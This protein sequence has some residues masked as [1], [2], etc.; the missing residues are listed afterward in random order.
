MVR[1]LLCIASLAAPPAAAAQQTPADRRFAGGVTGIVYIER[2]VAELEGATFGGAVVFTGRI[3]PRFS[4][5]VEGGRARFYGD[6]Q[7]GHR[8]FFLGALV[9][10][11]VRPAPTGLVLL[12]GPTLLHSERHKFFG[13]PGT[14][15]AA[16]TL[17]ADY[18]WTVGE[19]LALAAGWR[20]DL[21]AGITVHR[22]GFSV[23][24]RF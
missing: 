5:T 20:S 8:D 24:V 7:E 6:G 23:R 11:H 16:L 14:N 18:V 9:G 22:P 15:R 1:A 10:F 17:G 4:I 19:R 13:G 3:H 2:S 12:A 21:A